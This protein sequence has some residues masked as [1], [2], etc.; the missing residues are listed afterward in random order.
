MKIPFLKK[1]HTVNYEDARQ[2][3]LEEREQEGLETLPYY[4]E[5][6]ESDRPYLLKAKRHQ[7]KGGS[8][9]VWKDGAHMRRPV[10]MG[11]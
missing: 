8:F 6:E 5:F 7:D 4:S 10:R 11:G 3:Q 1:T 9:S 2:Q